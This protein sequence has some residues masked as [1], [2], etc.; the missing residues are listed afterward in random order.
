MR[1]RLSGGAFGLSF[2][3]M[4][5]RRF[6]LPLVVLAL[7]LL[8]A[9]GYFALH[10]SPKNALRDQAYWTK[11]IHADPK[12]AYREF[13]SYNASANPTSQHFNAHLIGELLYED[14]G[15]D[16]IALCDA[17]FGFGC[18]HGF[19]GRAISE[20]GEARV[21]ELDRACVDAFGP[22]GAGCQHGIGHGVLE[23]VGYGNL[24]DAL[25]LCGETTSF[26]PLLGCTSGVFMEY[27]SPLVGAAESLSSGNRAIDPARPY[28]PC[29]AVEAKYRPVCY[30]QLG[31]WVAPFAPFSTNSVQKLCGGLSGENRTNCFVGAGEA[32]AFAGQYDR[33]TTLGYCAAFAAPDE[34]DCRAGLWWSFYADPTY[35][36]RGADLCDYPDPSQAALCKRLGDLTGGLAGN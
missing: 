32:Y 24:A 3:T 16:G 9:G 13:V 8:A 19:F 21:K 17:S 25:K 20:G 31:A 26:S 35:R 6:I 23:Y 7:V 18:Y 15:I 36:T 4:M 2:M 12:A 14:L 10:Q 1:D 22:Y 29:D 34:L 11:K 5:P 27:N 30:Q 28:E 33:T